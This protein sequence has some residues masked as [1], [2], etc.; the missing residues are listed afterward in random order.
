[1]K[2]FITKLWE[3]NFFWE[4]VGYVALGLCILAQV[5]VGYLFILAQVLYTVANGMN[6][7][8]DYAMNLPTANKVRDIVFLA[9]S[10]GLI[11]IKLV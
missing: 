8:R 4:T 7:V 5:T 1:M 6:I 11:I 2:S 9:I 10:I 3:S